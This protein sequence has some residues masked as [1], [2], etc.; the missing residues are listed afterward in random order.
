M[1]GLRWQN[2]SWIGAQTNQISFASSHPEVRIRRLEVRVIDPGPLVATAEVIYIL[3]RPELLYGTTVLAP[4]GPGRYVARFR[5]EAGQ[6]V[7]LITEETDTPFAWTLDLPELRIDQA[8]Y[9]GHH[10]TEARWGVEPDGRVYRL[11]HERAQMDARMDLP[12]DRDYLPGWRTSSE[13][14]LFRRLPAWDPWIYD[15]GW[16][17]QFYGKDGEANSPLLGLFAGPASLARDVGDA[18]AGLVIRGRSRTVGLGSS[19]Q[20][21]TGSGQLSPN[22]GSPGASSQA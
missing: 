17:W 11:A 10:A 3:D 2:H 5:L 20:L 1:L 14:G 15:G 13:D 4:E 9:R 6:P 7:V 22:H 19:A 16:Y 21:R 18:G 12:F 8:R